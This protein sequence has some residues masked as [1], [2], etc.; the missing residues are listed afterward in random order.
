M[1]GAVQ[2][3]TACVHFH[4]EF[5]NG[6]R[7]VLL[8][9]FL[10]F[11]VSAAGQFCF[12]LVGL[13]Q[14]SLVRN[15]TGMQPKRLQEESPQWTHLK[16]S[17]RAGSGSLA[18]GPMLSAVS[19]PLPLRLCS[20]AAHPGSQQR[21]LAPHRFTV[22]RESLSFPPQSQPG[23]PRRPSVGRVHPGSTSGGEESQARLAQGLREV[24]GAAPD[25]EDMGS[26]TWAKSKA[27]PPRGTTFLISSENSL[28]SEDISPLRLSCTRSSYVYLC[29]V[30][31][32]G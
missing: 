23:G 10:A 3:I 15:V 30:F 7:L 20:R 32:G 31:P 9:C 17:G 27:S 28:Y 25:G 11:W 4:M 22:P 18:G 8:S 12:L 2:S 24:P 13:G 6:L 21:W 26:A 16:G 5:L 19:A 29:G 1:G 14:D